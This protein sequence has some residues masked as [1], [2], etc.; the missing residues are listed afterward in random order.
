[1]ISTQ[2][3]DPVI[4]EGFFNTVK[5]IIIIIIYTIGILVNPPSLYGRFRNQK[6]TN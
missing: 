3:K 6:E 5:F 2:R 1:M 4:A